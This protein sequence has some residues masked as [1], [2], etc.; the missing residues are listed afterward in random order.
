MANTLLTP[1]MIT[2]EALRILKNDLMAV[3]NV[4]TYYANEFA[5]QGMKIGSTLQIRKPNRFVQRV[6][7]VA[8]I[9]DVTESTTPLAVAQQAGVDFQFTSADMTLTI[10]QFSNRYIQ[11]AVATI[12]NG[13]DRSVLALYSQVANAVGIPGVTPAS[14]TPW[15]NAMA[16]LDSNAAPKV[17]AERAS[18]IDPYAQ[19]SFIDNVK[20]LF[21]PGATITDQ[22]KTG[23][24]GQFASSRFSMDQNVSVQVV[25]PQGGTPLVNGA[26]QTGSLLVTNGWTAAAA[27]RLNQGDIFTI[28]G[29]YRVNPQ[30]RVTTGQ[31]QQFVVTAPVSSDANGNATIPVYPPINPGTG[32]G[33]LSGQYQ[34]VTASPASGAAI[35]V[36]GAAGVSSPQ[37]LMF[38]KDAFT[39]AVIP[40]EVPGGVDMAKSVT[41]SD[42]GLSMRFI[43]S[44]DV[45]NDLWISR[46]DI[47][48][49]VACT[50]PE[51]AVRVQG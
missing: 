43:R 16:L 10:D 35:N 40:M 42:S 37:N 2:Q 41:D 39:L 26:G 36:L 31:L 32:V 33:L 8:Q 34:N 3:K 1:T 51:L 9:Q 24:M 19:A 47:L 46:F 13:V 45:I 12:A 11:P 38:H 4:N 29:V 22:Y 48:Y 44:Y 15:L 18:I 5:N 27:L 28:A 7:R 50:Y 14:T 21:N 25:G 23:N 30:S 17:I 6:G 49:G 20:G